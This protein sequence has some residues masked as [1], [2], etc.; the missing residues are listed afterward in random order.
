VEL[1]GERPDSKGFITRSPR[2]FRFVDWAG[3]ERPLRAADRVAPGRR[4]PG[5][6]FGFG[7][8]LPSRWDGP[9]AEFTD[10]DSG[11][12][13]RLDTERLLY[14]RLPGL[15][16]GR[17]D[18]RWQNYTFAFPKGVRL[19]VSTAP[20]PYEQEFR[21]VVAVH[22][23]GK[24]VEL[25]K[26]AFE[27]LGLYPSPDRRWAVAYFGHLTLPVNWNVRVISAS[28]DMFTPPRWGK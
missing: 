25:I 2:G 17:Y 24:K 7:R 18:E 19:E 21:R 27:W 16:Q 14:T 1:T 3:N 13:F 8:A 4:R 5:E 22:P 15:G 20:G 10:L 6:N 23:G 9:V 28:G 12:R 26:T 11:E